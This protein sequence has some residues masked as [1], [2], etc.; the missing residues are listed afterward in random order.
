MVVVEEDSEA[1][2]EVYSLAEI[3]ERFWVD[4]YLFVKFESVFVCVQGFKKLAPGTA[5]LV[6]RRK[7]GRKEERDLQLWEMEVKLGSVEGCWE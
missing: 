1:L 7:E 5:A 6:E 2:V 3:F 4:I